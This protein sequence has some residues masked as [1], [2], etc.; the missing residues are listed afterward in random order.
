MPENN[1]ESLSTLYRLMGSA[2]WVDL[3]PMMEND[4]PRWPTHPPV[5]I[6][7]T[8]TH[9]HDGYYSQTIFCPEHA[10]AHV[11]SPYHIH[12][13]LVEQTIETFPVDFLAGPCKVI[14]MEEYNLGPGDLSPAEHILD[15]EK[16]TGQ[17]IEKDDILLLNYGWIRRY[18]RTDKDW[19][20]MPS[21]HR[22]G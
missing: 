9:K 3:A 18:W 5:V 20:G 12:E 19:P 17:K 13:D 14:Q 10:G 22:T 4:M 6:H 2:R 16:R 8:V 11:D 21:I 15:W 7:Q 1:K